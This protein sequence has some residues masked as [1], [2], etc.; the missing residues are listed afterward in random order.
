M[1]E[2]LE[3]KIVAAT[4]KENIKARLKIARQRNLPVKLAVVLVGDDSASKVYAERIIRQC[5]ALGVPTELVT[6]NAVI[7]QQELNSLIIKLNQDISVAGILPMMPLPKHLSGEEVSRL[8]DANKDVDALNPLSTGFVALGRGEYAPCTPKAVMAILDYYNIQIARKHVVIIG[9]S[10]VVGKPLAHL[11]LSRDATVTVCHS[12][13]PNLKEVARQADI[14][15]SCAGIAG[16]VGSD[17]IK[18]GAVVVDVGI[19]QV[20]DKIVGD[21]DFEAVKN[22][23][24]A[25]T[26]VPGGVGTVC[27]AMVIS[28]LLRHIKVN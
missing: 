27:T 12:K 23:A 9:R 4:V 18:P 1:A 6:L 5:T 15:V 7:T 13:T 21:V 11:M 16:L 20:D 14:L 24:S 10:N 2:L 22:I 26:P 17:M 25:I 19:N 8:I 28:T 3:G